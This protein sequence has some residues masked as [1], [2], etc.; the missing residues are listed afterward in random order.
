MVGK[1]DVF[2]EDIDPNDIKQGAL[3]DCW[4]LSAL[5]SLAERPAL[6]R[7]LFITKEYNEEGVYKVKICKNGEWMV[8]TVD[9][10]IPC[11]YNGGPLFSRANGNEL[12]V[13]LLE[14][15]YAKVN[16]TYYSLR[17]GY[18]HQGMIDLSGCPTIKFEFPKNA[19]D[20]ENDTSVK[21][22]C[23]KIWTKIKEADDNGYLISAET[24]GFDDVTEGGG[25]SASG[26]LVEGHAYSV[27]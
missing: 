3:S 22:E 4:F 11:Y 2:I 10:Y 19:K 24:G 9:D 16:G 26:G 14:K 1:I 6:V 15:A 8:V 27:I 20:Y 5:A 25:P 18:T 17:Y 23:D 7:R 13:L 21:A 12:W